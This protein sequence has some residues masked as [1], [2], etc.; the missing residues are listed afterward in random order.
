[1]VLRHSV[2]FQIMGPEGGH[3]AFV[4]EAL[5][6]AEGQ[7][8]SPTVGHLFDDAHRVRLGFPILQEG[9]ALALSLTVMPA[10]LVTAGVAVLGAVDGGEVGFVSHRF[11][12]PVRF[13]VRD[14]G[15]HVTPQ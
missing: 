6:A 8:V 5:M 2:Q 14:H 3:S 11:R 4:V 7:E 10:D 15:L 12:E 9:P 13:W 1:V